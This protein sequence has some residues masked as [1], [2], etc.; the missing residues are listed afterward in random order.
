MCVFM[1]ILCFHVCKGY[2][3]FCESILKE[4]EGHPTVHYSVTT[5]STWHVRQACDVPPCYSAGHAQQV[6][7]RIYCD[8][9][10]QLATVSDSAA[11]I[12]PQR[13]PGH[14]P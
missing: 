3:Q 13:L 11:H 1:C 4:L 7:A 14:T 6:T 12:G 8:P 10:H 5:S 9:I 2:L